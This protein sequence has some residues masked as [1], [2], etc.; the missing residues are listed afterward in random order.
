MSIPLLRTALFVPGT[1]PDRVDKALATQT[2]MVIIDLEDAVPPEQKAEARQTARVKLAEHNGA[3]LMVRCNSLDSGHCEED[4][5]ALTG[6]PLGHLFV[7]KVQSGVEVERL[8]QALRKLERGGG[9]ATSS[10]TLLCLIET[11]L[12]VERCFEVAD[13]LAGFERAGMLA[14][15]AADYSTDMGQELTAGGENLDFPRHRLSNASHAAGLL[16][17]IDSPYMYDLKDQAL[18]HADARRARGLG[19]MGKLCLHPNQVD[20]CNKVF[21]PTSEELAFA[22]EVIDSFEAVRAKGQGVLMVR[23]KFVDKPVVERCQRILAMGG[24]IEAKA[25]QKRA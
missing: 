6:A 13:R 16:G 18:L 17:P 19:Y 25:A 21:S 4:L 22:R 3:R 14:F 24:A 10:V 9:L 1:R 8:D 11:P 7:P 20:V 5:G 2:D 12:G 15:G 23:G